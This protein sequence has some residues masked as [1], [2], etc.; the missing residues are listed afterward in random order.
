MY[1]SFVTPKR[2]RKTGSPSHHAEVRS[3]IGQAE[4]NG[5]NGDPLQWA[6]DE[7]V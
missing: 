5:G 2:R 6:R 4:I 1:T 3:W 7:R